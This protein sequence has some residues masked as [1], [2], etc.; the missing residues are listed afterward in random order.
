MPLRTRDEARSSAHRQ[1]QAP[2]PI[3]RSGC[4]GAKSR[5]HRRCDQ[6]RWQGRCPVAG[7]LQAPRRNRSG[8]RWRGQIRRRGFELTDFSRAGAQSVD[9]AAECPFSLP[10]SQPF[11]RG[12]VFAESSTVSVRCAAA[13]QI[14]VDP[15]PSSPSAPSSGGSGS[16]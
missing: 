11:L 12:Y 5:V 6:P 1:R 15:T 16:Q 8:R 7:A 14:G 10:R 4:S 13:R 3:F 9:I 2:R